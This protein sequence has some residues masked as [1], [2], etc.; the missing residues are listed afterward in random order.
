MSQEV[1]DHDDSIV[2]MAIGAVRSDNCKTT[3]SLSTASCTPSNM[4]VWTDGKTT[5]SAG[6][7]WLVR[8]P[9][10]CFKAGCE[11]SNWAIIF[12][13]L[14]RKMDDLPEYWADDGA[15]CGMEAIQN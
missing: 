6:F 15:I 9:N 1:A 13:G 12:P 5:G 3:E 4:F 7:N 10:G 8:Q 2:Y 14:S 11:V